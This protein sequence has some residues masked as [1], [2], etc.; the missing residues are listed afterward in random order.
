MPSPGPKRPVWIWPPT[1]GRGLGVRD[2]EACS[3]PKPPR[4]IHNN[5]LLTIVLHRAT[6]NQMVKHPA[7]SL[8]GLFA[9]LA[10]PTRLAIVERLSTGPVSVSDLARPFDTSLP[11]IS[12]HLT[13]LE[14][15]GVIVRTTSGRSRYCSLQRD[16]LSDAAE[17]LNRYTAFWNDRLDALEKHLEENP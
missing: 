1:Q 9:A 14:Q 2:A 5:S 11:A 4:E 8:E 3:S 12:K 6:L 16:A 10:D 13:V 7:N 15:A 17:W